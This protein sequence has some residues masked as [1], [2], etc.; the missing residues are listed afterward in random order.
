[1]HFVSQ[2][3]I[4]RYGEL[5]AGARS[6]GLAW[7]FPD[8]N[9]ECFEAFARIW[10]MTGARYGGTAPSLGEGDTRTLSGVR[11]RYHGLLPTCYRLC[12]DRLGTNMGNTHQKGRCQICETRISPCVRTVRKTHLF[13][14]HYTYE[15]SFYQDRIGT[16][17]SRTRESTQ[18]ER[19]VFRRR[20]GGSAHHTV[21]RRHQE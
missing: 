7:P 15:R 1:M 18:K 17:K 9:A 4:H 2:V 21:Q 16:N 8:T 19:F 5:R 14:A 6:L 3:A 10:N 11:T 13:C 20:G 12:Q